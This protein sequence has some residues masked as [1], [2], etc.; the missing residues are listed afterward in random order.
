MFA[1][2]IPQTMRQ[3]YQDIREG[4][5]PWVAIGDFSHDWH[6]AISTSQR[7]LLVAEPFEVSSEASQ[8]QRQWAAFC[9]ASV[10]YLCEQAGVTAPSWIENPIYTLH[11]EDTFFTSPAA[12]S[13]PRVRER[14]IQEAPQAFRRRNVYCSARVYANKYDAAPLHVKQSA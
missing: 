6:R 11:D 4:E 5:E 3:A 7:L 9:A 10:E 2:D 1:A 14:L 13:K 12:S 8:E